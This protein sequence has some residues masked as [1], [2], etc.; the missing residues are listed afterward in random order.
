M[1]L[2]RADRVR[3]HDCTPLPARTQLAATPSPPPLPP[4]DFL[5]AFAQ[6]IFG[7]FHYVFSQH[8]PLVIS[9]FAPAVRM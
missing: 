8:T 9:T 7:H 5:A 2:A 1:T 3:A 6:L 4:Q